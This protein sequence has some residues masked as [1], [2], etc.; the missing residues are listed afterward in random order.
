MRTI[1][2]YLS[3]ISPWSYLGHQR[4]AR[5][6]AE[7]DAQIA[8]YPADFSIIFP[9]TGG[10]PLPKRSPQ[11]KAYRM[12]ELKRWRSHLDIELNLEPAFFPANDRLAATMVVNARNEDSVAAFKLAGACLRACWLEERDISD[13]ETLLQIARENELDGELLM[14]D[15]EG[16]LAQ[17]TQ[18]SEA[19]LVKGVFG[20]PSYVLGD[21]V[22]W[23]QDRLDFLE[24]A[25][26]SANK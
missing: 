5:M 23:G 20:A 18:D 3:L 17:I 25:L 6:A 24:R 1:H 16:A 14:A 9:A 10:I 26:I 7:N 12:Q 8:I 2:Y 15:A 21:E 11:R 19:A 4:L 22:F 13:R